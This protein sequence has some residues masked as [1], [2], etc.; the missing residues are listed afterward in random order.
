MKKIIGVVTISVFV[1]IIGILIL[2]ETIN[3]K[4]EINITSVDGKVEL[5]FGKIGAKKEIGQTTYQVHSF[6]IGESL[7]L[8]E[9]VIK[10]QPGYLYSIDSE[11]RVCKEETGKYLLCQDGHYFL[12]TLSSDNSSVVI[13]R[14]LVFELSFWKPLEYF[15]FVLMPFTGDKHIGSDNCSFKWEDTVGLKSF[16][17]LVEFYKRVDKK[18][19]QINNDKTISLYSDDSQMDTPLVIMELNEEGIILKFA[20]DC[21]ISLFDR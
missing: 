13:V 14:E 6:N 11:N 10:Q 17:D 20:A 21:N 3:R 12:I 9:D 7:S 5:Y 19:Y 15:G 1:L 2:V 18:F 8:W 16:D 4:Y